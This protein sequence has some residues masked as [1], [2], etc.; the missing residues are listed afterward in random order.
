MGSCKSG[1]SSRKL[2]SSPPSQGQNYL[3]AVLAFLPPAL[4]FSC[5]F[6]GVN[7]EFRY[8]GW[9][10]S[11]CGGSGAGSYWRLRKCP[12]CRYWLRFIL[13]AL[14]TSCLR[15]RLLLISPVAR[16]SLGWWLTAGS[17]I[18]GFVLWMMLWRCLFPQ[19]AEEA[20]INHSSKKDEFLESWDGRWSDAQTEL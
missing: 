4:H 12:Y 8:P 17:W 7:G 16:G 5:P 1:I 14:A 20:C 15:S 2:S 19:I 3:G 13:S 10:L 18:F 9:P 6:V 11:P